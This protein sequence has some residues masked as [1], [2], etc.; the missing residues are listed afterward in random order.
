MVAA[1]LGGEINVQQPVAI[2]IRDRQAVAVIIV[3]RLVV[4]SGVIDDA[5]LKTDPGILH[6][7]RKF[8]I[9]EGSDATRAGDLQLPAALQPLRVFDLFRIREFLV[10]DRRGRRLLHRLGDHL[11]QIGRKLRAPIFAEPVIVSTHAPAAIDQRKSRAVQ[12]RHLRILRVLGDRE[13]ESV[14]TQIQST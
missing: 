7:V 13:L 3:H 6:G 10:S 1:D 2:H 8:E 4:L 9:V 14:G 11:C 5:V 12:N